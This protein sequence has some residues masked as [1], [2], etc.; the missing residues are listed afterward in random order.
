MPGAHMESPTDVCNVRY[1]RRRS[2]LDRGPRSPMLDVRRQVLM[3][4]FRH[5]L[6]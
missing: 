5:W 3:R 4:Y 2:W 1:I 6:I